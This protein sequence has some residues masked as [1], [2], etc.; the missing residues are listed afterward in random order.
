ML[1]SIEGGV[2][3]ASLVSWLLCQPDRDWRPGAC[4][5]RRFR[6]RSRSRRATSPSPST[7]TTARS[8]KTSA[9]STCRAGRSRQEFPDVSAQIQPETVTLSGRG[10]GIVEQNF[11]FD[12]LSPGGAH[13]ERRRPDGDARPGQSRRPAPRPASARRILA[14]NGGVV[15]QIGD[16]IE[17]LRDDGLPARVIFDQVPPTL[18]ARPTLSVTVR[19]RRRRIA[20]GDAHLSDAGAWLVGRLCRAVRRSQRPDGRAG[21]DHADQQQRHALRERR[22]P[23]W[24]RARSDR[25]RRQCATAIAAAPPPGRCAPGTETAEPRAAR[26]LLSLSAARADDD[27]R[28]ADQAGQ[29]P[30]RRTTRP[31]HRGYEFRNGWLSTAPSSRSASNACCASRARATRDWAMRCR[32]A[33]SAS[34]SATRAA[35]RSSSASIGSATRRWAPTSA[36][37]PA[38]RSTSRCGPSSSLDTITS[39]EWKATERFRIRRGGETIETGT[40]E[41]PVTT[42]ARR[43]ATRDQC[44]PGAGHRRCSPG[45]PIVGHPRH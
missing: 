18:R 21:L 11:D 7:T 30:R 1:P 32:P 44:Q 28:Q 37:P 12:L 26:R 34:I 39:D 5:D 43:C 10:V 15:M 41:R 40:L 8:L 14:A 35:I 6:R 33:R 36:S 19:D 22:R 24:S 45:W 3:D 17:V 27:R 29:L 23:C 16:R 2:I 9:C 38:R 42:G 20:A 25:R 4:P 31:P 13:A